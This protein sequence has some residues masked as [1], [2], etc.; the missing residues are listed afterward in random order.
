M[1]LLALGGRTPD[2]SLGPGT[3]QKTMP[4]IGADEQIAVEGLEWLAPICSHILDKG[5]QM[6]RY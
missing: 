3:A 6:V 5:E 4:R 1:V 2:S